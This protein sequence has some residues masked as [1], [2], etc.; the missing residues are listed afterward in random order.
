MFALGNVFIGPYKILITPASYGTSIFDHNAENDSYFE[1]LM[2]KLDPSETENV[3]KYKARYYVNLVDE[4]V[5][6]QLLHLND[7]K[8]QTSKTDPEEYKAFLDRKH[9]SQPTWKLSK[10]TVEKLI[11]KCMENIG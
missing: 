5:F 10:S 11:S 6:R 7:K 3:N 9:L 8:Q 4:E 1:V 2:T